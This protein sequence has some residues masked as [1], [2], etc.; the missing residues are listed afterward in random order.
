MELVVKNL[1]FIQNT[2]LFHIIMYDRRDFMRTIGIFDEKNYDPD[3]VRTVREAVRAVI[4]RDGKIALVKS[5]TEGFY[6][7]PGGGI[8]A[9]ETHLEALTRET[10]E[11]AGLQII[12]ETVREFGFMQEIRAGIY[13]QEIFDQTSYYYLAEVRD[14]K[15]EQELDDYE[16]RLGYELVWEDIRR[17]YESNM[18]KNVKEHYR[19]TFLMRE[20]YVLECLLDA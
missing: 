16:E 9:G 6:K 3:W 11:E 18:R 14:E 7:F 17:A 2:I 19:T 8:E 5:K 1:F 10:R 4:I 15:L 20:S 12:P 13:G